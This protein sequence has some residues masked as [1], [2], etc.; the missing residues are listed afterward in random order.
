MK[1]SLRCRRTAAEGNKPRVTEIGNWNSFRNQHHMH[2]KNKKKT[3]KR[4]YLPISVTLDSFPL[5]SLLH[6][7]LVFKRQDKY[8]KKLRTKNKEENKKRK[9]R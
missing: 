6:L 9:R 8:S 2:K 3:H 7:K 1:E 5:A 4:I